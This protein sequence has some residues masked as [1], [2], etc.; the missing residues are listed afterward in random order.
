[1]IF[2]YWSLPNV[3]WLSWTFESG[4]NFDQ[5]WI[6]DTLIK[7]MITKLC[8]LIKD[9]MTIRPQNLIKYLMSLGPSSLIIMMSFGSFGKINEIRTLESDKTIDLWIFESGQIF[10]DFWTLESDKI[11][12]EIWQYIW[13]FLDPRAW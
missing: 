8:N 13:W 1:M 4:K 5:F 3:W 9:C 6:L 11:F 7:Y 2:G 10:D 12:Y